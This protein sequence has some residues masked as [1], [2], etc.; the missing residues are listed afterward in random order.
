MNTYFND[1]GEEVEVKTPLIA[2]LLP[3]LG[4]SA[5]MSYGIVTKKK[6]STSIAIGM[7]I[8]AIF[9]IPKLLLIRKALNSI[10]EDRE[11]VVDEVNSTNAEAEAEQ[12]QPATADMLIDLLEEISAQNNTNQN[13]LPKKEYFRDV[14]ESFTQDE[15][16]ATF[17]LL[18]IIHHTPLNPTEEE[19]LLMMEKI[20]QLEEHYGKDFIDNI[21]SRLNE[22]DE[23]VNQVTEEKETVA[24]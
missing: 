11:R 17:D 12:R 13:F 4:F 6:L 7:G 20:S 3:L 19:S 1:S 8:G 5:G 18:S 22:V 14:F 10:N 9:S 2:N 24:V 23:A 21:N 16:D 15:R